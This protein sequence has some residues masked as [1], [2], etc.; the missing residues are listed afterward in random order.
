MFA[1][2]NIFNIWI[3]VAILTNSG[4]SWNSH[5]EEAHMFRLNKP[6]TQTKLKISTT[7]NR[8]KTTTN[9]PE[10]F[11]EENQMLLLTK[12]QPKSNNATE[13][14]IVTSGRKRVVHKEKLLTLKKTVERIILLFGR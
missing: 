11:R 5:R 9:K 4:E 14:P 7:T 2:K 8:I 10:T 12:D 1:L 3:I 13:I 6:K